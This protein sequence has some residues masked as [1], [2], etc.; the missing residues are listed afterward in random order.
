MSRFIGALIG[1]GLIIVGLIKAWLHAGASQTLILPGC[2]ESSFEVTLNSGSI[3]HLHC[4]G[5]YSA[6]FGAALLVASL[7]AL[8]RK[9]GFAPSAH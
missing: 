8:R 9:S 5:C 4:W 6:A 7:I 1:S 3:S 2:F